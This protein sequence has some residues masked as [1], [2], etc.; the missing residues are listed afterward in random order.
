MNLLQPWMIYA[1]PLVALPII[2]HLIHRRRQRVVEWGA[3]RF[4]L[5]KSRLSRGLQKLRHFLILACRVLAVLTLILALGRPMTGGWLGSVAGVGPDTV[6]VVLDRSA[7]MATS[8]RG[9]SRLESGL[10]QL[11]EALQVVHAKKWRILDGATG[12]AVQVERPEDL[13]KLPCARPTG[14]HTDLPALFESAVQSLAADRAGRAE[15]WVCSD[16]Q[17]GDWAPLDGRWDNVRRQLTSMQGTVSVHVLS[18]ASETPANLA[19][20]VLGMEYRG[21]GTGRPGQLALDVEVRRDRPTET[22]I[23]VPVTLA[24][25][26]GR[27]VVEVKLTG[28]SVRSDGLV[29]P[30]PADAPTGWGH[31]E[32]PADDNPMDNAYFLTYGREPMRRSVVVAEDDSLLNVLALAAEASVRDDV[33][34]LATKLPIARASELDL[35]DTCLLVWQGPLPAP[36]LRERI[37][38]FVDLGGSVLFLPS[39]Q[40]SGEEYRGAKWGEWVE[41]TGEHVDAPVTWREDADLVANT[42]DGRALPLGRVA[43]YRSSKLSGPGTELVRLGSERPLL[44]R[45]PTARGGVWFLS[46]LPAPESSNMAQQGIILVAMVQRAL[47][48]GVQSLRPGMQYDAGT[49]LGDPTEWERVLGQ[50]AEVLSFE[51]HLVPGVLRRGNRSVAVNRPQVEDAVGELTPKDLDPIFKGIPVTVSEGRGGSGSSLVEEIWKLFVVFVIVALVGE[52]VLS[53]IDM[54]RRAPA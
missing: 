7:S 51:Q 19:V 28:E 6:V 34:Y 26:S 37:D 16:L 12:E 27:S 43:V 45:L 23:D 3:M 35:A 21:R 54:G 49:K 5:A 48:Q 1:L 22:P 17:I 20:R 10:A 31:V 9:G 15:I 8:G 46:T 33:E 2:I 36:A 52:A 29:I 13:L 30:L 11:V 32:L 50:G 4:L 25:G 39:R 44:K 14:T 41:T 24:F 42:G 40:G 38:A 18:L 53:F 47:E